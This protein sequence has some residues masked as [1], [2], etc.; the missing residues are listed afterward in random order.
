MMRIHHLHNKIIKEGD[1]EKARMN[2]VI[3]LTRNDIFDILREFYPFIYTQ[4]IEKEH[5]AK[6]AST[7]EI[8]GR[9]P[10]GKGESEYHPF[11]TLF[12]IACK[13][14]RIHEPLSVKNANV[15]EMGAATTTAKLDDGQKEEVKNDKTEA[16]EIAQLNAQ[17]TNVKIQPGKP[18]PLNGNGRTDNKLLCF[19]CN[20]PDH[21]KRECPQLP[22]IC[23]HLS[24]IHI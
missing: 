1:S 24:L 18:A 5:E 17:L 19:Q 22:P 8:K 13:F 16:Q 7:K 23:G 4:I 2:I 10:G 12:H 6:L 20:S 14:I 11:Q 21:F 9:K 3:Q 15:H